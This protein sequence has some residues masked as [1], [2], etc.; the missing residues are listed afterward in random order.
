MET[1]IGEIQ[2]IVSEPLKRNDPNLQDIP[3]IQPAPKGE[4]G[5]QVKTGAEGHSGQDA[6]KG[7]PNRGK[8]ESMVEAVQSHLEDLNIQLHFSVEEKTGD[9]IVRV[10]NRE[11]G[12]T[13]RQ[14]PPE[15]LVT[16]HQKLVELRG[17]LFN[18]KV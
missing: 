5:S 15:D 4:K 16:L 1:K 17:V 3:L 18:G 6:G 13:I 2:P 11:T 12:E 14:I 10:M 7:L 8:T 9:Y